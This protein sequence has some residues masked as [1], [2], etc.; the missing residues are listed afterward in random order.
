LRNFRI[1]HGNG[2][3]FPP[4]DLLPV[5]VEGELGGDAIPVPFV[6]IEEMDCCEFAVVVGEGGLWFPLTTGTEA[7]MT[8]GDGLSWTTGEAVVVS[9]LFLFLDQNDMAN[10]ESQPRQKSNSP[11]SIV[12]QAHYPPRCNRRVES[13]SWLLVSVS[14]GLLVKGPLGVVAVDNLMCVDARTKACLGIQR[15]SSRLT[16][17][18][19]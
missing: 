16:G 19:G 11:R 7:G 8:V 3:A 10:K 4:T 2:G 12:A 17:G 14:L 18:V 9:F 6:R 1:D 15:I 5:M 13:Y